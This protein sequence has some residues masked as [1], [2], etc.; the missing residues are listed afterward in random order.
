VRVHKKPGQ[1]LLT[2][3]VRFSSRKAIRESLTGRTVNWELLPMDLSESHSAPLP[4]AIPRLLTGRHIDFRLKDASYFSAKVYEQALSQGGLPGV[5]VI[6]DSSIRKQ[7]FETQI[8]TLL[9][10]DLRLLVQTSLEYR[11]LR[12]LLSVLAARQGLPLEFSEVSRSARI[13]VPALRRVLAALEA[14]FLIRMI[15]TE[16]SRRRPVLFLKTKGKRPTSPK[17]GLTCCSTSRDFYFRSSA[18]N[19]SI[20]PSWGPASFSFEVAEGHS[21]RLRSVRKTG[22]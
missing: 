22:C 15:D 13:S 17:E 5:F 10:R 19:G 4:D 1:F 6:R 20:G 3:S 2:G 7:R 11:T 8:E 18:S 12:N 16:G 9:E 14:M 21:F